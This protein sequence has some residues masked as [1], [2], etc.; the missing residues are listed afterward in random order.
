MD[1]VYKDEA[2]QEWPAVLDPRTVRKVGRVTYANFAVYCPM[3]SYRSGI[4][5]ISDKS[6][7]KEHQA[8]KVKK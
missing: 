6:K 2:G 1:H 4:K 5:V 3:P 8:A 7:L